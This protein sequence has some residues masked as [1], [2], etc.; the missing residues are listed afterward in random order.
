MSLTG[1]QYKILKLYSNGFSFFLTGQGGTG[2]SFVLKQIIE[3]AHKE[4]GQEAV[5][6]TAPTGI[7]ARNIA[8]QTIQSWAG[9][10]LAKGTRYQLLDKVLASEEARARWM[11]CK[12]LVVD[13]VSLLSLNLFEKLEPIARRLKDTISPFG[14]IQLIF[15]GDFYQIPPPVNE[16]GQKPEFCFRSPMWARCLDFST[17]ISEVVRQSDSKFVEF[18]N[19]IRQGGNLSTHATNLLNS[20]T[21]P[22]KWSKGEQIL[23]LF[24]L[25]EDAEDE[26]N[27]ML[28]LLPGEQRVFNAIDGGQSK[29]NIDKKCP[30]PKTLRLKVG[31]PVMLIKNSPNFEL[32]NGSIG[33]IEGFV[34]NYPLVNF[35]DGRTIIVRENTWTVGEGQSITKATRRQLPLV[36]AW[37]ITIHKC[38]GLTLSKAEISL[39]NL[40]V[41]GQAYVALSRVK[42]LNG[43]RVKPGFD[44]KFPAVSAHVVQY[45][46]EFVIPV[47][48]L[49]YLGTTPKRMMVLDSLDM[50]MKEAIATSHVLSSIN[51]K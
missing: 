1:E 33:I 50:R 37:A 7:A 41:Q 32:V 25:R 26:N 3:N 10:G 24:A 29:H 12:F 17:E 51:L 30:A 49:Q 46:K 43:I 6:V 2:K 16:N 22:I 38:Q 27:K 23:K 36:L 39:S 34:Y 9:V 35:V 45:Y 8:G 18:L 15:S 13:K 21:R 48:S 44:S 28:D 14:G 31:A 40:F 42:T 11:K 19:E 4:L 20:L 47:S 5:A